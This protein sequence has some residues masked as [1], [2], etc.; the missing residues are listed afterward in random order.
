MQLLAPSAGFDDPMAL[1]DACHRRVAGFCD[2]LERLMAHLA[3]SG[4]DQDARRAAARIAFYFDQA[5]PHHH[6]D[7]EIDLLPLLRVRA[8]GGERSMIEAWDKRIASEHGEQQA[9]WMAL[10]TQ[11][12]SVVE[13]IGDTL[14]RAP[15]FIAMQREHF[16]FEDREV[17][18]RARTLLLAEDIDALGRAMA[19]RRNQP[20][21]EDC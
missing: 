2:T 9:V 17:F 11:L 7:E 15:E 14:V 19:R 16:G 1:L 4:P 6:A 18:P 3:T 5:A 21:P 8:V 13:G 10:R 12:Q 20:Y